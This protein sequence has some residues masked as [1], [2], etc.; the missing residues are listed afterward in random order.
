MKIIPVRTNAEW[1]AF[2][3]LPYQL[4][5][6]ATNWIP[7][8]LSE[9]KKNFD[10]ARNSLFKHCEYQLF[11]LSDQNQIIGR[12]AVFIDL[13][14]NAYWNERTGLFGSYEC[15]ANQTAANLLL[16]TAEDWLRTRQMETIRGPWSFVSQ[17]WGFTA[18]GFKLPPVIMSPFNPAY[19]NQQVQEF[20]MSKIKD[21]LV[22]NCDLQ[23]GYKMPERFFK[24]IQ[25]IE[26]RYQVRVRP[27]CLKKMEDEVRTIV[28]LTNASLAHNWG[29]TPIS[30][31]EAKEIAVDL[32]Q[33]VHP[34]AVLFAEVADEPIG[35]LICLPDINSIL[36]NL[37]GRLF[38]FGIF[39]LMTGIRKL[40]RYRIWALG[41]IPKYQQKGITI[42]LFHKLH[43]ALFSKKPYL[44][45]NYVLEDN[46][47]MNNA[48]Q[49]LEFELVKKYRI[50]EKKIEGRAA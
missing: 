16:Q 38:P 33:I 18:E 25:K 3:K 24:Y 23:N 43:E 31:S 22:Y 37:N 20:G 10:P 41:I 36:K 45:A 2:V 49:Q 48:L 7:P 21:L 1:R 44:E 40:N 35:F 32:R 17:E 27:I 4:H 26:N 14:L 11:L 29:F 6:N 28:R 39:K 8:L 42:L 15:V 12:I 50:Y 9:Q 19:Y 34:E 13:A 46:H 5:R 30:E 47:L